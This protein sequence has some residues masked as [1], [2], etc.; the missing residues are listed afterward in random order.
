M[1]DLGGFDLAAAMRSLYT[2]G[3]HWASI[4][5]DETSYEENYWGEIIDPDGK[6]RDRSA[7]RE[8]HLADIATELDYIASLPGGRALDV[9]CGLGWLL[10]ALGGKWEKHGIEVSAYAA[11]KARR[12]AKIFTGPMLD[13]P[14]A[15]GT[16]DLIVMHHV[17]EHMTDPAANIKRVRE[18][19]KPGGSLVLG[20]PD[21]DSGCARRFGRNFRLLNDPTHVSLF[22]SDSMHRFLRDHGFSIIQVDY[23]FFGTRHFTLDNFQRLF[24]TDRVSPAFYGNFMTFYCKR[25]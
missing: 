24:A 5:A 18:L 16:F 20:T 8:M 14:E 4:P 3:A 15:A 11:E 6:R 25:P 2:S 23:P 9:G 12:Y 22:S 10:S 7:E 13:Y 21:F 17:I 1:R 19:L